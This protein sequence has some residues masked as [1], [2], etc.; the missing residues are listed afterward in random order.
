MHVVFPR[1]YIRANQQDLRLGDWPDSIPIRLE[2]CPGH[3]PGDSLVGL[4]WA[5]GTSLA[6][7][8]DQPDLSFFY[9]KS[10]SSTFCPLVSQLPPDQEYLPI[11]PVT[12]VR[13]LPLDKTSRSVSSKHG[14]QPPR[15]VLHCWCQARVSCSL[16]CIA[17]MPRL[18]LSPKLRAVGCEDQAFEPG[19]HA[20]LSGM[21]A[22]CSYTQA[23]HPL[24]T[25]TAARPLARPSKSASMRLM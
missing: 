6:T 17:R 18:S 14:L 3:S 9:Y 4:Q 16:H 20:K 11:A 1:H 22:A 5:G 7:G 23:D 2:Y 19:S 13:F 24:S 21:C 10:D 25:L 15:T 8:A 12:Q